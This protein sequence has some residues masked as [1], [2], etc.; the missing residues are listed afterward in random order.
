MS[1][2]LTVIL[3]IVAGLLAVAGLTVMP[4]LLYVGIIIALV[5]IVMT[6]RPPKSQ[7]GH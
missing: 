5:T 4:P 3:I 6:A 2:I 7:A 1:P